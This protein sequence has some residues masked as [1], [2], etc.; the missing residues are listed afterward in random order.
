MQLEPDMWD[1]IDNSRREQPFKAAVL[2]GVF[3]QRT[4]AINYTDALS[5]LNTRRQRLF[6]DV[7]ITLRE[8][9]HRTANLT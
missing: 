1:G 8:I 6:R 4:V 2:Q 7:I 9:L 5:W 3:H